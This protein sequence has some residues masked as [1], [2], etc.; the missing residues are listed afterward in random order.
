MCVYYVYMCMCVRATHFCCYENTLGSDSDKLCSSIQLLFFSPRFVLD[1]VV[2]SV[3]HDFIHLRRLSCV[4]HHLVSI[5]ACRT[6]IRGV[7]EVLFL[8]RSGSAWVELGWFVWHTRLG[9]GY[10]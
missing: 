9:S 2:K 5:F 7:N 4:A 10:V 6:S 1:P 8:C 3:C